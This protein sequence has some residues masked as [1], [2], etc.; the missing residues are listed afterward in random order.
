VP[1]PLDDFDDSW[2][3]DLE[4]AHP[5]ASFWPLLAP[6]DPLLAPYWPPIGPPSPLVLR[7]RGDVVT[8]TPR[9]PHPVLGRRVSLSP[10]PGGR[11]LRP[12]A[13]SIGFPVGGGRL[14]PPKPMIS[15][16]IS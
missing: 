1:K 7:G 12:P 9:A 2:V 8:D 11:G 5:V 14:D 13:F 3:S 15:G 4:W 16:P 10:H 6:I